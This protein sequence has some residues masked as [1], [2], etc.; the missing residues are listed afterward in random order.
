[1]I[2]K[3]CDIKFEND[4]KKNFLKWMPMIINETLLKEKGSC[5]CVNV[6]IKVCSF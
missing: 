3:S 6:N 1:M 5:E 4:E 2:L